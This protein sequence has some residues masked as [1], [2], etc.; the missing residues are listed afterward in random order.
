MNCH[1]YSVNLLFLNKI[2]FM[3]FILIFSLFTF[4]STAQEFPKEALGTYSGTMLIN[5]TTGIKD[6]VAVEFEF[7][8]QEPDSSWTFKMVFTNSKFGEMTKDYFLK[9]KSKNDTLNFLFDEQNGIL[10]EMSFLNNCFYGM[11]EVEGNYF[12][13]TLRIIDSSTLLYDL[14]ISPTTD[15]LESTYSGE[16]QFKVKS[17]KPTMQQTVLFKKIH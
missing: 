14:M 9:S 6:T 4:Y 13:S 17:Y 10:M 5:S 16:E 12:V 1:F 11:Y 8:E 7:L 2:A 15:P 3:K